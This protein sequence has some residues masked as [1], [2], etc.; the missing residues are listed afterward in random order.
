MRNTRRRI[1]IILF[2]LLVLFLTGFGAWSLRDT[3]GRQE[4][5]EYVMRLRIEIL[6]VQNELN[7][8]FQLTGKDGHQAIE[9]ILMNFNRRVVKM[10]E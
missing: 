4:K 2:S 3:I 5:T 1:K 7:E 9:E 10:L 6:N 8:Q